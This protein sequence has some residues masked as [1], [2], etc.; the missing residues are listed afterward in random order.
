MPVDFLLERFRASKDHPAVIWRDEA[1]AYGWLLENIEA[2]AQVL[3]GQGVAPGT[4]VSLRSDFNPRSIAWLIAL[5]R[6][7]NIVVPV[8]HAVRTFD[9]FCRIAEVEHVVE[10]QGDEIAH[11]KR[12][13]RA[14]HPFLRALVE[15]GRPGLVLFSSGSTGESKA[16]VHD[17]VPLLQK[18]QV[19]KKT[20]RSIAFL[21]FD[22][23]GGINTLFYNLSNAGTL[24]VTEKRDP[25]SVCR[26]IETHRIELLPTSPSFLQ[27]ILMTRAYEKRDLSSL[28][29]ITYGTEAMPQH[30]LKRLHELFPDVRLKQTYGLSELGILRSESR[31]SDSLWIKVGGEDYETRIVDGVLQ[32]RA[33]TAMLGYLNAPCPFD[34]QGWFNTRDKVEVDGE[35]IRI[36]GRDTD[37]INVGGQKVYPAEVESVLLEM[38]NVR[39]VSVCGRPNPIMGSVVAAKVTLAADEPLSSLKK[40]MRSHCKDRLESFK[41]PAHVEIA[42]RIPVSDRFKKVR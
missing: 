4:V 20:L 40:R 1:Y 33:R 25:E 32:V 28:K 17:F 34:E 35:W 16:A 11:R 7:R 21:L 26:L 6:N 12:Q 13:A 9:L 39:E 38:D 31:A 3:A 41:I 5:V 42:E 2:A 27:M 14:A 36:L 8:S 15:K 22:H 18:F 24:V 29:M 30:T 37:I 23:I 10:F 19:R